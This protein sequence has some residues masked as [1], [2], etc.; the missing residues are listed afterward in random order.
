MPNKLLFISVLSAQGRAA[1][2]PCAAWHSASLQL[3]AQMKAKSTLI[4][5]VGSVMLINRG[6]RGTRGNSD[7]AQTNITVRYRGWMLLHLWV[8]F[9]D[10]NRRTII[11]T[12]NAMC[13]PF[14]TSR[15]GSFTAVWMGGSWVVTVVHF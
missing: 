8:Q 7:T 10:V 6:D 4:F 1:V 13:F 12:G 14:I 11:G 2:P 15:G 3:P 9:T 5:L